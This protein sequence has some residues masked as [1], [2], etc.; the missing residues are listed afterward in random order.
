VTFTAKPSSD[1][2]TL[3]CKSDGVADQA[4]RQ[5]ALA[6]LIRELGSGKYQY[7]LVDL[8]DFSGKN[9]PAAEK[10]FGQGMMANLSMFN[11]VR[12]AVVIS[13]E[14]RVSSAV[15]LELQKLGVDALDFA[16]T[17]EAETWLYSDKTGA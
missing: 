9:D 5:T 6:R 3:L 8:T 12:I 1:G 7:C 13:Q 15:V 17:T 2:R 14:F 16:T 10:T 11:G 4:S